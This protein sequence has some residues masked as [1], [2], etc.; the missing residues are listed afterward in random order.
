M[1]TLEQSGIKE[2]LDIEILPG[3]I[4]TDLFIQSPFQPDVR[5]I[6]FQVKI[7]PQQLGLSAEAILAKKKKF[8]EF[9]QTQDGL[10]LSAK[11]N[12]KSPLTTNVTY[13]EIISEFLFKFLPN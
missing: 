11:I 6:R 13:L 12:M 8:T 5:Y 3:L 10:L 7:I 9:E 4:V 1:I 2:Q